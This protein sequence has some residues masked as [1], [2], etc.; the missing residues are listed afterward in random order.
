MCNR[1]SRGCGRCNAWR[2][3]SSYFVKC[4]D[5]KNQYALV[6]F[7]SIHWV[8][9]IASSCKKGAIQPLNPPVNVELS[10]VKLWLCLHN[11]DSKT[12]GN[13][14][15][16]SYLVYVE[17][18]ETMI[19]QPHGC[20]QPCVPVFNFLIMVT[21]RILTDIVATW[22]FELTW[23]NLQYRLYRLLLLILLFIQ[24]IKRQA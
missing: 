11:F 4:K 13:S 1:W 6:H 8:F 16:Y 21:D 14:K 20:G 7:I 23:V 9:C 15:L 17:I 22:Y 19:A 12:S 5:D 2:Y 10:Y 3:G 24:F 18:R